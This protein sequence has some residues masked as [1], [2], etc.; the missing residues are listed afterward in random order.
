[1]HPTAGG[2]ELGGVN[3]GRTGRRAPRRGP[4]RGN[5]TFFRPIVEG[6]GGSSRASQDYTAFLESAV[7]KKEAI[8]ELIRLR[9]DLRSD[10]KTGGPTK[11]LIYGLLDE[12]RA[13]HCA[14]A[15]L[16]GEFFASRFHWCCGLVTLYA[17]GHLDAYVAML[18]ELPALGFTS[19]GIAEVANVTALAT[20]SHELDTILTNVPR[21]RHITVGGAY[22]A[23]A[24]TLSECEAIFMEHFPGDGEKQVDVFGFRARTREAYPLRGDLTSRLS[25]RFVDWIRGD[26]FPT[27]RDELDA[28]YY[29]VKDTRVP[30]RHREHFVDDTLLKEW[31]ETVT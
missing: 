10:L 9:P 22:L 28:L 2:P 21:R 12:T 19:S 11:N 24:K 14:N 31:L 26:W 8:A 29:A 23:G 13:I 5:P 3:N 1:M 16:V 17:S 18:G 7:R 15:Y 27:G 6:W 20:M 4:L 25:V 30:L